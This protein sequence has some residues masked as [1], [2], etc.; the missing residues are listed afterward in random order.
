VRRRL[1]GRVLAVAAA[2]SGL[3]APA[4]LAARAPAPVTGLSLVPVAALTQPTG[5][6]V[7]RD[8][9][10]RVFVTEKAG[11]VLVR[12]GRG[13][14]TFLD[15][16]AAVRSDG[17]E[18]GL[19]G[20]AFAPDYAAS[21]KFYVYYTAPTTAPGAADFGSDLVISE[22]RR[23]ADADHADP[24]SERVLL[25]I[26]H[27]LEEYENG[28]QLRFGPDGM[29]WI[30]TGDGG[31]DGDPHRNAQRLDPATNDPAAGAD[32]LLGKILRID[33]APGDGCG[34]ACTIPAGNPG[35]GAREVWAYGLRNPWRFSF[36]R[37]T[38]DLA[39]A[40]VGN[41]D[42]EEVDLAPAPG[43]GRGA[44]YGWPFF[45]AGATVGGPAPAGCCTP[46]VLQRSHRGDGFDALIGGVVVRDPG[47]P[48]LDGRYVYA[49]L[50]TG[51]IRS[52]RFVGGRAV[53]D[54][55]T[56]LRAPGITS[57]GEDACGRVYATT[58][59][60]ALLR[61]SQ[62]SGACG[63]VGVALA[64]APR[65]RLATRRV[66]VSVTCAAACTL[67]A[68]GSLRASARVV[69]RTVTAT[70]KLRA[71]VRT[72]VALR[73]PAA[74]ARTL[75][76]AVRRGRSATVRIVVVAGAGTAARPRRTS[77]VARLTR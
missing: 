32:A 19:L 8:D 46:P 76:R 4:A 14:S 10:T 52:T 6:A 5:I 39:I 15:L 37:L 67:K 18:Q 42:L 31:G 65:Q 53:E 34:G 36:D 9:P 63:A 48:A 40:D 61:I 28:G 38:G 66:V 3:G 51:E 49:A 60:G 27:R 74:T 22:L 20:L 12:H 55:E 47:V 68:Y 77:V 1:A 54:R 45:E 56:G 57:F 50:S 13:I 17:Y 2:A 35:F 33:P 16:T 70:R 11:R 44:N 71:G 59:D 23:G 30:G 73:V 24:A 69:G 58:L 29:L 7:A 75:Q 25:R 62:G 43:L 64:T 72:E 26:P 41:R 21:G